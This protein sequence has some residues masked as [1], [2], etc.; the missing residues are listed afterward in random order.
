VFD[1]FKCG[2]GVD[3]QGEAWGHKQSIEIVCIAHACVCEFLENKQSDVEIPMEW[4]MQKNL[5]SQK[6]IKTPSIKNHLSHI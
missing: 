1:G 3:S 6:D 4:N 5:L 2:F